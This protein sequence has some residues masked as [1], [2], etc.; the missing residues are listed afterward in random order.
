M[1]ASTVGGV[2]EA[3]A[4]RAVRVW[5]LSLMPWTSA[6]LLDAVD[7]LV[8][9][10]RPAYGITANL[11]YAMLT[12]RE[13]DLAAVN[14]DA[15]FIVADGMPLLW[16]ARWSGQRLPQRVAGSDLIFQLSERAARRGH[17]LYLLGGRPGVAEEAARRLVDLYPGLQV[18]GIDSPPF[19]PLSGPEQVALVDRVRAARPDI[20]LVATGQPKGERWIHDNYLA[21]EVPFCMQ[22]GASVDFAAGRIPRAPLWMQR[23]GLE[24]LFRLALEPRRLAG[25]YFRNGVF[26]LRRLVG[27]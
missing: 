8:A 13:A 14:R 20:L 12:E 4:S 26:F 16:A 25:R 1:G 3:M 9:A 17:R 7:R 24:W 10:R 6:E 2:D 11:N 27:G 5:G 19:R 15:A 18:V 22:V 23:S 21:L